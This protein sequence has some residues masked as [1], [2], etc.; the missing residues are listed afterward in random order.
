MVYVPGIPLLHQFGNSL[1]LTFEESIVSPMTGEPR[2]IIRI[3]A[4]GIVSI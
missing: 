2:K 3:V 4:S 1:S